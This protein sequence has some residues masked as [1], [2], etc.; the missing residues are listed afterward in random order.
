MGKKFKGKLCAYCAVARSG[1]EDH[2]FAREFFLPEDRNN[3]PKA[4]ACISCNNEKSRLE[5]YFTSVLPFGGRHDQ[6]A[7]NLQTRVPPRLRQNRKLREELATTMRPAWLRENEGLFLPG[8][9]IGIDGKRLEDLV[10]YIVRGL[11]W[12]H[13]R[14]YL[15]QQDFVVVMFLTGGGAAG[16]QEYVFALKAARQVSKDLG[17]GTVRYEGKQAVDPPE[18][19]IWRLSMYGG[20]LLSGEQNGSAT[21]AETS[22]QWVVIT[23]PPSA[24]AILNILKRL[25]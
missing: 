13:W 10:S 23:G 17:R 11:T 1:T 3:L 15:S 22:S 6:A 4:P 9:T 8:F 7:V 20:L 24:K 2:V 25:H 12:Y 16:F 19:T 14:T 5:Q 18:L 21:P